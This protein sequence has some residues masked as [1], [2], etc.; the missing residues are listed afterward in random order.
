[1]F[2]VQFVQLFY[3]FESFHNKILGERWANNPG[4]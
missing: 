3:V 4:V 1:M 2:T